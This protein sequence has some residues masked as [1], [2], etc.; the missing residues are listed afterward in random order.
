M[1]FRGSET[2]SIKEAQLDLFGPRANAHRFAAN[3]LRL[4]LAAFAYTLIIHLR[5]RAL[6]SIE[7]ARAGAATNRIELLKIGAEA[8]ST[9]RRVRLLLASS[10]PLRHVF[11]SAANAL[12]P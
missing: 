12:A 4:L 1:R 7:L 5:R 11:L 2:R 9:T 8:V 10:D 6:Q 3:Q